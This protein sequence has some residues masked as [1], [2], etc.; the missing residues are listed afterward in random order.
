MAYQVQWLPSHYIII[1]SA[2]HLSSLYIWLGDAR[3]INMQSLLAKLAD[4]A[5]ICAVTTSE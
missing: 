2:A 3:C 5:I 1:S 4:V